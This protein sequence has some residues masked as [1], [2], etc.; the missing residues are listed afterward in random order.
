MF[1]LSE[2]SY[3]PKKCSKLKRFLLLM[4]EKLNK[5]GRAR[6]RE[7]LSSFSIVEPDVVFLAINE[8]EGIYAVI[9]RVV[10]GGIV[11]R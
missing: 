8:R 2:A 10:R 1:V 11:V 6:F 3:C 5:S 7:M 4:T 9:S